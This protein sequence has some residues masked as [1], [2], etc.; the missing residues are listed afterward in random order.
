MQ[1][2]LPATNFASRRKI[3]IFTGTR[4]DYGHLYHLM[5]LINTDPDLQLQT[6]VSGTHLCAEFGSTAGAIEK[7]GFKIDAQVDMQ[8]N[9]DSSA[10][11]TRSMATGLHG[12][13]EA[14]E[15]LQPDILVILGDRFEAL[16]V[17]QAA[18]LAG[19]PIAHLHG[20]ETSEGAIDEMIRHAITKM[21]HYH[22]TA[23]E[24][25][26]QRVIQ[27][28]ENPLHC[29]NYGAPGLDHLQHLK[30]LSHEELHKQLGFALHDKNYLIT[31][32]PATMGSEDPRAAFGE[33]LKACQSM[34][35]AGCFFT[36]PNADTAGRQIIGMIE[37]YVR[38]NP[39]QAGYAA[40]LGQLRY[41]SLMRLVDAVIGNSSSGLVE[42]PAMRVATINTGIRQQGRLRSYSVIDAAPKAEAILAAVKKCDEPAFR[43]GLATMKPAYGMG[44]VSQAILA[45]L[46]EIPAE[47][48]M[49]KKFYD[50]PVTGDI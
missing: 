15:R 38:Q 10:G 34:P 42:A 25:Y 36:F 18:M 49:I 35:D 31:F 6:L 13:A 22:F 26:R 48:F 16:A 39:L 7:D 27:M 32:H 5:K 2:S 45:K 47:R 30:F 3:C 40:S 4:A 29:F 44:N 28:G 33:I 46:K 20:G 43:A 1:P 21:A 11:I 41:L 8:L 37:E 24:S 19:V 17:A 12:F 14:F 9:S 23:A 50:L